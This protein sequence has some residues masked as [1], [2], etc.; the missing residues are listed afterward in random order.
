MSAQWPHRVRIFTP[1]STVPS[2]STSDD[3]IY[4]DD[5]TT[6]DTEDLYDGAADVQDGGKMFDRDRYGEYV[7]G[8]DAVVFLKDTSNVNVMARAVGLQAEITWED[9][10]VDFAEVVKVRRLDATVWLK[11]L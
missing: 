5:A 4:T 9:D 11:R 10:S 7:I 1:N 8:S 6:F 2:G 3:G